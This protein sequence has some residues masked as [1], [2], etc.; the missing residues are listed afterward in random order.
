MKLGIDCIGISVVFLCHDGNGN[1]LMAKRSR[2]CRDEKEK[3]DIGGG[4][5]DLNISVENTLKKEIKE[6]YCSDIKNFEFLGYRDVHRINENGEKTHWVALDFKV[7]IDP[8]QAK[9]G[10]VHKFDD[11][12]WFKINSLPTPMHSQ[13]NIF[14][15]KYK[16][17]LYN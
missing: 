12:N 14:F 1:I 10:E 2:N 6:E 5:V 8:K 16:N 13:L 3:W 9:I 11:I 4:S 17:K 15:S 7:Q